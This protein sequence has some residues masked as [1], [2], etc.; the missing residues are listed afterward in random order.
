MRERKVELWNVP[1]AAKLA[2]SRLAR[3][4]HMKQSKNAQ[5][6]PSVKVRQSGLWIG[7][8]RLLSV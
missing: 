2:E 8:W 7:S 6:V 4:P 3:W 1:G 5:I